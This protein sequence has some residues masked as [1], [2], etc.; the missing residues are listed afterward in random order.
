[1]NI[2]LNEITEKNY[3]C[4]YLCVDRSILFS[5]MLME[6][7]YTLDPFECHTAETVFMTMYK[8]ANIRSLRQFT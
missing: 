2:E 7:I 6:F 5:H 3:T 8:E 4:T 1:M